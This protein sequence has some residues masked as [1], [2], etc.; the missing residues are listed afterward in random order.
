MLDSYALRNVPQQ[1]HLQFKRCR[2]LLN[3]DDPVEAANVFNSL[4]HSLEAV[5]DYHHLQERIE[6]ALGAPAKGIPRSIVETASSTLVGKSASELLFPARSP[7]ECGGVQYDDMPDTCEPASRAE[8][9]ARRSAQPRAAAPPPLPEGEFERFHNERMAAIEA[10]NFRMQRLS[11]GPPVNIAPPRS[12]VEAE[13]S[14]ESFTDADAY[15]KEFAAGLEAARLDNYHSAPWK[16][17][18]L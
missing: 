2:E 4:P 1:H 3:N 13:Q 18:A 16:R 8:V 11:S 5:S 15:A 14:G 10:D 7:M 12:R 17:F 6:M 9:S